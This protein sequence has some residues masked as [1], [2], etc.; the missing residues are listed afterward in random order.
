MG[1]APLS[2]WGGTS[3]ARL[4]KALAI[5]AGLTI[6][7][8]GLFYASGMT[9]AGALFGYGIVLLA[10]YVAIYETFRGLRAR[11]RIH[12][13]SIFG[14]IKALYGRNPRRYG[15]YLIHLG[16][17]VIGI[18]IIGSSMFQMETQQ[19]LEVGDS[20][21][22]GGY[23]MRY[24][25]LDARQLTEDGR[26]TD[27]ATVTVLRNSNELAELRP[28]RDYFPRNEQSMTIAGAHSTLE[29]DFYVLLVGWEEISQSN[30]TFKIY[31]N[32]LINLIWWGSLMLI[33]GTMVAGW[34]DVT[35]PDRSLS[36]AKNSELT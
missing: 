12:D 23:E 5:P 9:N 33:V 29:N 13:E 20:A 21:Y 22:I 8:I 4:G 17:T 19:T 34:A 24:D 18:G 1:V 26:I 25:R 27:I 11:R 30:V 16:V 28:R 35:M 14:S 15:G 2:A 6:V 10:G 31:I 36:K 32:P 3:I 7:S